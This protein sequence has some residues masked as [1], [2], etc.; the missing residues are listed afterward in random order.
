MEPLVTNLGDKELILGHDW[1]IMHNPLINWKTGE[2]KFDWCPTD[3]EEELDLPDE[4]TPATKEQ[5]AK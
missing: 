1:L 4:Y 2:V 3:V 5:Q